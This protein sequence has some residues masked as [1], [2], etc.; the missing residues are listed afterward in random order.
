[1][2]YAVSV[3]KH[4]FWNSK[5][6]C[7]W[8]GQPALARYGFAAALTVV[9]MVF[10]RLIP[11][12]G[13]DPFFSFFMV[14]AVLS[15]WL[16]GRGPGLFAIALSIGFFLPND[17]FLLHN[18]NDLIRF[19]LFSAA[20]T[21]MVLLIA[22]LQ[23]IHR[24]QEETEEIL[25]RTE[26]LLALGQLASSMAHEINNPLASVTN[27]HFLLQ[28]RT[29]NDP[30]SAGYVAAAQRELARVVHIANQTLGLYRESSAPTVV[31]VT[32]TLDDI[33]E[34]YRGKL[35]EQQLT[36]EKRY[37]STGS[38]RACRGDIRQLC[39]NLL[40]NA[41]EATEP[42][43]TVRLRVRSSDTLLAGMRPGV[44]IIFADSGHGIPRAH[45]DKIFEPFFTTKTEKG[46]GLGLWVVREI[47]ER[48]GGSIRLRSGTAPGAMGTVF[49][50]FLPSEA[51]ER[52]RGAARGAVA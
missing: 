51:K 27:L 52:R 7:G 40:L 41:I 5:L 44:R 19:L 32:D 38:L 50:V 3:V 28:G 47:V 4:S 9:G 31:K 29:A 11:G 22:A 12:V 23:S 36:I 14:A 46:T 42:G 8:E 24:R 17:S 13:R 30:V 20:S 1:M 16:G 18:R 25:H 39:S 2:R 45:R 26:K 49:A 15:A 6:P 34:V 37:S 48:Y 43:G 21:F 35:E 33:L 10:T